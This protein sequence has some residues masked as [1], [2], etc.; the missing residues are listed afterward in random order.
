MVLDLVGLVT[1]CFLLDS[2]IVVSILLVTA[3]LNLPVIAFVLVHF[4]SWSRLVT[5]FWVKPLAVVIFGWPVWMIL[6]LSR[7]SGLLVDLFAGLEDVTGVIGLLDKSTFGLE[8]K[9]AVFEYAS[10]MC[11]LTC[12]MVLGT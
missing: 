4:P 2:L 7:L 1:V 11:P 8:D 5:G 10:L 6:A 9:H 3:L 12:S